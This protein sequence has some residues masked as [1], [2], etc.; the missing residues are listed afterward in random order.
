MAKNFLDQMK[1]SDARLWEKGASGTEL[2]ARCGFLQQ[3]VGSQEQAPDFSNPHPPPSPYD[4]Q[5][6]L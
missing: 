2:R 5:P 4:L 1:E 6:S 3:T